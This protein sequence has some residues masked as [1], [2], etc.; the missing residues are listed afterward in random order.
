MDDISF[1]LVFSAL[2]I[3]AD[4][5]GD[6]ESDQEV[7]GVILLVVL[8]IGPATLIFLVV[9]RN[10][11]FMYA[12]MRT[13][14]REKVVDEDDDVDE[15]LIEREDN[16][17]KVEAKEDKEAKKNLRRANSA[18]AV[19]FQHVTSVAEHGEPIT[20][21][22]GG[23]DSGIK[24]QR[25]TSTMAVNPPAVEDVNEECTHLQGSEK[26][27]GDSKHDDGD[28][29]DGVELSRQSVSNH[30]NSKKKKNMNHTGLSGSAV[31]SNVSARSTSSAARSKGSA[32]SSS[33]WEE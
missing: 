29:G 15:K 26:A 25:S 13:S 7:F 16:E 2:M 21:L 9:K 18:R 22:E 27:A 11:K 30:K 4:I 33:R 1:H 32:R 24:N 8:L 20:D 17:R 28:V 12:T 6:E 3:K 31:E 14:F 19:L 5:S 10:T 23:G